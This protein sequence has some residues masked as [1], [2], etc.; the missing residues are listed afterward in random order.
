MK[1]DRIREMQEY[2]VQRNS[3]T[4]EELRTHFGVSMNTVRRDVNELI[5][6]GVLDKVYGG[7]CVRRA[8]HALTPYEVR[9]MGGEAAKTKIGRKAAEMVHDGDII[10]IDSGTTTMQ[11]I[12]FLQHKKE[13][14]VITNN[15]EAIIRALP[16]ENINIIALPGQLRRKTNSFTGDD[17]VRSLQR[18]NI[19]TAFI[20]ATGISAHGVTNSSPSEYEIKKCAAE[21]CEKKVL[22]VTG[23]KFGVSGLM[24]FAPVGRFQYVVTDRR[25]GEE[26][27]RL[28]KDAGAE[29]VL[30]E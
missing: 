14:T 1:T 12:D 17:A 22:L 26:Y 27:A 10:F 19:R 15:L 29:L 9:R 28:L 3:A 20:A 6:R 8:D 21:S 18:Y 2:I 5:G 13:L 4:M 7:V 24:T 30:A 23:E 16:Y 25:P 11:M